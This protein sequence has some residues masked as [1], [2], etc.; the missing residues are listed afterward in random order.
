MQEI[1]YIEINTF[2]IIIL[3]LIYH[4]IRF[5]TDKLLTEQKLFMMLLVMNIVVLITDSAITLLDGRDGTIVRFFLILSTVIYY[6]L[7]SFICM[8]WTLYVD[9]QI[10]R[11]SWRIKKLLIPMLIPSIIS[12]VLSVLSA[13]SNYYF[14]I[15]SN[16]VYHRGRLFYL[17]AVICSAYVVHTIAYVLQYRKKINKPFF[18]SFIVFSVPPLIGAVIQ[19]MFYG[20]TMIWIGITISLLIVFIN[21]QNEQMYKDYLTGLFNRRQL[22]FYLQDLIQKNRVKVAGIMLDINSF[23]NINDYYGHSAGDQALKITSQLLRKTFNSQ[24]FISRFGGDEFV[25]LL[26]V[27]SRSE[28][29]KLIKQLKDNIRQ[30]NHLKDLPYQISLSIGADLYPRDSKMSG[31]EFLN[32]IDALMYQNKQELIRNLHAF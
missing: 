7:H 23:K 28:L 25:I 32:H 2:A 20:I 27:S 1:L 17:L 14:Y 12:M 5:K 13:F 22:D 11:K 3:L 21:I 9:F 19:F 26:E 6:I 29:D 18:T 30:F 24:S 8:V 31:Q 4:N 10:N 15:D 16:N